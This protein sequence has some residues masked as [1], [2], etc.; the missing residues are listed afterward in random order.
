K[1]NDLSRFFIRGC[2]FAVQADVIHRWMIKLLVP[3]AFGIGSEAEMPLDGGAGWPQ[4]QTEGF[5]WY[6]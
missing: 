5:L 2:C 4:G 6:A 1:S 3:P